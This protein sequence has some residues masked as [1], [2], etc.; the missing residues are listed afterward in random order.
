MRFVELWSFCAVAQAGS[1]TRAAQVLGLDKSKV[2]RDVRTLEERLG[3][4]LLLRTTR[5]VRLTPEGQALYERARPAF[6]TIEEALN[7]T[8]EGQTTAVGEVRL[9]TTPELGRMILA[10]TLSVF[11][12]RYPQISLSVTL[13]A[14]LL[15]LTREGTDLALRVGRPG[16][17]Q[18]VARK[19]G[20][21]SS[22]FYAS[23]AYLE[24][25]GVPTRAEQLEEHFGLW[26]TPPRGHRTFAFGGKIT[27]PAVE[28]S[29]FEMLRE[30]ARAATGIALLPEFVAAR[31]E[32]SGA[33][34]RVLPSLSLGTSPL[35]LVSR[36]PR[37]LTQRVALLRQHLLT[38]I[39]RLTGR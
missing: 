34:V 29:D 11:R 24:R 37:Q 21:L 33:L 27:R 5:S 38:E 39:P 32:Q 23:P 15:D 26:P 13:D 30:L 8:S 3:T 1:F 22:G 31:D 17:G 20:Q 2:S 28:C 4:S 6:V 16:G 36:A 19:V 25:R 9:T 18:W 14:T 7:T 10:P 12:A 35:F